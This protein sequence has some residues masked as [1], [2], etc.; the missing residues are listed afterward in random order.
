[1]YVCICKGVTDSQIRRGVQD[2]RWHN[3]HDLQNELQVGTACG[4]C[5]REAR[6]VM[7]KAQKDCAMGSVRGFEP[8]PA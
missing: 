8:E 2:R 6:S 3:L 4:K 7:E 1:M 5:I